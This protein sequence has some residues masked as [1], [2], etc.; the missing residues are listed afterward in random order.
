MEI[1]DCKGKTIE[2]INY[3]GS[4]C[5]QF[6]DGSSLTVNPDWDET[7]SLGNRFCCL[8]ID[9]KGKKNKNGRL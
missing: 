6:E 8:R 5:I 4:L 2:S 7:E 9:M 1:S 3:N